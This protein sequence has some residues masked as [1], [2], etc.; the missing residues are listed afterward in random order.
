MKLLFATV[1]TF[2]QSEVPAYIAPATV[3]IVNYKIQEVLSTDLDVIARD[4]ALKAYQY[5]RVPCAVEHG[6]LSI[7]WLND[8]PGGLS[9]P[10]WDALGS[11]V[12]DL[13]PSG[14]D[15]TA[16]AMSVVGYCDG[17][18][19][20]LHRGETPGSIATEARGPYDFQWDPIFIA[21]GSDK[22]FGQLGFPDKSPFSAAA[23]AW[24]ALITSLT[25]A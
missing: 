8:L 10:I 20:T 4:K 22:T 24:Q 6:G 18:R 19:I 3:D 21:E 23:K 17:R 16:T 11:R 13:I 25:S 5:L 14:E 7:G 12:C 1:N 9:K 15:R 2:K